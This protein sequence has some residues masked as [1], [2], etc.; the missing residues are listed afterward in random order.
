[1]PRIDFHYKLEEHSQLKDFSKDNLYILDWKN[2]FDLINQYYKE[3]FG[4]YDLPKDDPDYSSILKVVAYII[5]GKIVSFAAIMKLTEDELEIGAVSTMETE[6]NKGYSKATISLAGEL[7]LN[8]GE[9]ASL[10]TGEDNYAMQK[11]AES[12]GM[13]KVEPKVC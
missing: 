5:K 8:E 13:I 9:V 1:M 11:V 4:I 10:T 12:I 7:I 3:G 2:D 6:R